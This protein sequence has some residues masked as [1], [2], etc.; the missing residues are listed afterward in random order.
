MISHSVA[1]FTVGSTNYLAI[2]NGVD[3][4]KANTDAIVQLDSLI[5]SLS[6]SNFIVDT[7]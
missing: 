4:F 1:T 2:N 3:G 7:N 5:G 6:A